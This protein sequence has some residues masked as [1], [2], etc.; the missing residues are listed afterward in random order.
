MPH[1]VQ[2]I[3]GQS[4]R[5]DQGVGVSR[6][7]SSVAIGLGRNRMTEPDLIQQAFRRE[8]VKEIW[9]LINTAWFAIISLP[10]LLA[11]ILWRVW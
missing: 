3:R 8:A 1:R 10:I 4:H 9:W 2:T 5:T 6:F 7:P 11:L